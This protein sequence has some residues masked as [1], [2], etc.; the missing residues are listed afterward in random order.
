VTGI[1]GRAARRSPG[2]LSFKR[3]PAL[4]I[5]SER[6]RVA[7][8]PIQSVLQI[9]AALLT[10]M[11][12][13][14]G[15]GGARPGLEAL[16]MIWQAGRRLAA[17]AAILGAVGLA[18]APQ[19]AQALGTGAAVGIGLGAFALGT[20]L[21]A[22][23]YSPYYYPNAYYAPPPAYYYPAPAPYYPPYYAPR[24][25]WSPYYRTYVAC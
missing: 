24:S 5:A 22:P 20:A 25:C 11:G 17:A 18:T 15:H 23:Y 1:T 19:P 16:P 10:S 12:K 7:S 13:L 3:K 4:A 9:A 8:H 21:A 14:R 2:H 6:R